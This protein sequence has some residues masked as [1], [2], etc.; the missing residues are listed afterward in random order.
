MM[1]EAMLYESMDNGE[2]ERVHCYLCG[3]HCKISESKFGVCRVRQNR[4]GKLYTHVYGETIASHV[5]PIEKKPLY[6]FL[7]GSKSFSIATRG[8]NFQC[9]FC[10][11]WQISQ[12]S[13][14]IGDLR[15]TP[16]APE[17]IARLARQE[18]CQSIAYTYT[19]PTIYFEYAY[20]TS[21]E[22]HKVG[23]YNIFVTNGYMTPEAL[24]TIQPYLDAANVDLKSFRDTFYRRTCNGRLQPVLD[25][26]RLMRKHDIWLEVT[27]LVVPGQNDDPQELKDIAGFIADVDT[28]IPW[29]ISRFHPD[30]KITDGGATPLKTLARAKTIGVEAG[31]RYIYVGNVPGE[32]RNTTCPGCQETVIEREFFSAARVRLSENSTCLTCGETIAGVFV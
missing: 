28:D 20:D 25:T 9:G 18:H 30:Y 14:N 32:N 16:A 29:H 24:T 23:V 2:K 8:C 6:H 13:K 7:P 26:I 10:Q 12:S 5:D 31:L 11:N 21:L 15:G 4:N 3:H 17:E 27:T 1:R 19:E 22:A